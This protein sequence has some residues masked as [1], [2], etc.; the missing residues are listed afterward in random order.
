M[1]QSMSNPVTNADI[2]DVL[3]SIRRLVSEE[4]RPAASVPG[5]VSLDRLVLTPALRV[6]DNTKPEEALP[7]E[8]PARVE[9]A[10]QDTVSAEMPRP[11]LVESHE[12]VGLKV[13]ETGRRNLEARI[14]ELE[15]VISDAG[16]QQWEPD[17][18]VGSPNEGGAVDALPWNAEYPADSEEVA[19]QAL[20]K[21]DGDQDLTLDA[22]TVDDL[23]D[24]PIEE[25]RIALDV[26]EDFE[27]DDY[28]P[29]PLTPDL[30]W[31]IAQSEDEDVVQTYAPEA[32]DDPA[33]QGEP[34]YTGTDILVDEAMLREL[35]SEIVR[36]ELQGP[37]GERI[38]RNVRK[39]VRREIMRALTSQTLE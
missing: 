1:G 14:A 19:V 6:T 7:T 8:E 15:S 20:V 31:E 24:E 29:T 25:A 13:D 39:L 3:S 10:P 18:E 4:T 35:V 30:D 9:P 33:P 38:T 26:E 28:E 32:D 27:P 34:E 21:E 2:E 36:Q 22:D 16:V 23:G 17:G 5:P 37:L 11:E 12:M